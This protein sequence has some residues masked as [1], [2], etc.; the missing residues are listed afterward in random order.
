MPGRTK[1]TEEGNRLAARLTT[2]T[3]DEVRQARLARGFTQAQVAEALGVSRARVSAVERGIARSMTIA[4]ISRQAAA[5]GLKLSI[6]FY[7]LGVALRD[8]AQIRYMNRFVGRVGR[9]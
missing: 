2:E 8:A 5:V 3:A 7:P 6:K 1:A 4:Q 9:S